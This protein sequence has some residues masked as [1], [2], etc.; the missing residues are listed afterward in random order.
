MLRLFSTHGPFLALLASS[1]LFWHLILRARRHYLCKGGAQGGDQRDLG[2][3]GL[4]ARRRVFF[5]KGER[6][7][8][9]SGVCAPREPRGG[10]EGAGG[11][12]ASGLGGAEGSAPPGVEALS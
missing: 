10:L 9:M 6:G 1:S 12:C 11:V 8:R 4:R 2:G 7:A 3:S 5:E